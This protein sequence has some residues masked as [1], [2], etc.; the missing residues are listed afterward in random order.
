VAVLGEQ[1]SDVVR[2]GARSPCW[3]TVEHDPDGGV[4]ADRLVQRF[5]TVHEPPDPDRICG[6]DGEHVVG[7][8]EHGER[9]RVP[10][11]RQGVEREFLVVLE[12]EPNIDERR[13]FVIAQEVEDRLDGCGAELRPPIRACD[14]G[15]HVKSIRDAA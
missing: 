3:C 11:R 14:S 1:G 2:E 9:Y 6:G 15:E 7:A 8:T 13:S 5:E 10:A 4:C 12:A